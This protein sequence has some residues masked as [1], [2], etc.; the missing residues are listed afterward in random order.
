MNNMKRDII[1]AY[2]NIVR[3]YD[4]ALLLKA[5]LVTRGY[6][7]KIV[8]KY[9]VLF[10]ARP[11]AIVVVPNCYTSENYDSY[12]YYLNM[13][14]NIMISLQYE[15][16]LSERVEKTEVHIPKGK[17]RDVF[18]FCWGENC[19]HRLVSKG[20]SNE[21]IRICGAM[22]LD[23]LR[24]EF[25]GFYFDRNEIAY[26][27]NLDLDK[28]WLLY[29]SS[30]SYVDNP[31]ITKY[32]AKELKDDDFVNEFSALSIKSQ[33]ETLKWFEK[34]IQENKN[35]IVIYRKHPV[36][37]NSKEV[38]RLLAKYPDQFRDISELSVK[39]WV[40]VSDICATWFSTSAAEIYM[41]KRP[42]LIL[43][44]YPIE[45]EFDVPFYFDAEY[46]DNYEKMINKCN[47]GGK[48]AFPI[49]K[50]ILE[51]YYLLNKEPAYK[52]IAD[53]I[54]NII[55]DEMLYKK[56]AERGFTYKRWL[57]FIKNGIVIKYFLK[58]TYQFLFLHMGVKIKNS[59]LRE[60]YVV[61][62]WEKLAKNS[63]DKANIYKYNKLRE[64]IKRYNEA[65]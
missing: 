21:K 10:K 55:N 62:E 20:I 42:L 3:E 12:R 13:N 40:K 47:A 16:V 33:K 46:I 53:Q 51:D 60:K 63:A 65:K 6:N 52:K 59:K 19:Y 39:Q 50:E 18:L 29:I 27:Y 49:S 30:F 37:A 1:I 32:T 25:S 8:Y 7:V 26:K 24:K 54:V 35:I 14:T 4:N 15:Q 34:L 11:K 45:R 56:E 64:I 41:A 22:Q 5:E 23:F 44:P 43:R 9:D 28:K 58:R 48:E 61:D 36:E 2:E 57:Y 38:N 17:A 31:I